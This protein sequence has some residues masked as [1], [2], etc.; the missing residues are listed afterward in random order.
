MSFAL[1]PFSEIQKPTDKGRLHTTD[2]GIVL[3]VRKLTPPRPSDSSR[4]VGRAACLLNVDPVRLYVPLCTRL[5]VMQ[6]CHLTASCH[7]GTTRTLRMLE[8]LYRWIGMKICTRWWLP[9]CLK[10]QAQK[11]SQLT[12]RWPNLSMPLP[13]EPGFA[14]SVD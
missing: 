14:V 3:L 5:W 10:R 1:T 11:I 6:A 2:A 7:L 8:R 13:E 9:H 4:P 12:V